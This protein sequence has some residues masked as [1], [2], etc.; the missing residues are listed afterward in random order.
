MPSVRDEVF[1]SICAAR[2]IDIMSSANDPLVEAKDLKAIKSSLQVTLTGGLTFIIALAVHPEN[3]DLMKIRCEEGTPIGGYVYD[4]VNN[5]YYAQCVA[6]VKLGYV[7]CAYWLRMKDNKFW[8]TDIPLP[9]TLIWRYLEGEPKNK[10]KVF[11][12]CH[13]GCDFQY[14][15]LIEG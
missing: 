8:R 3:N 6:W 5:C 15:Q 7:N 12:A 13:K 14:L 2:V 1:D 9:E 11:K 10:L 4:N